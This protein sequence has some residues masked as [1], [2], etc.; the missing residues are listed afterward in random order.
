PSCNP[1]RSVPHRGRGPAR[2]RPPPRRLP[3]ERPDIDDQAPVAVAIPWPADAALVGGGGAGVATAVDGRAAREQ[4]MGEGGAAV[5]LERAEVRVQPGAENAELIARG[6]EGLPSVRVRGVAEVADEVVAVAGEDAEDVR[7]GV[8]AQAV[9]VEGDD[10]ILDVD[11]VARPGH[12]EDAAA[13][14]RGE[15][16]DDRAVQECA[17]G[18]EHPAPGAP[19]RVAP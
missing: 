7:A 8:A 16:L 1:L 17:A 12:L 9:E 5:V 4:G 18:G 15:I 13:V 14:V 3:L 6:T 11:G 2:D 19:R 10:R